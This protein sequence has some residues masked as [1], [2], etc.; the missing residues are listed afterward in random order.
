MLV[1]GPTP[2][3]YLQAEVKGTLTAR[4]TIALT[5]DVGAVVTLERAEVLRVLPQL[6]HFAEHGQDLWPDEGAE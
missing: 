2:A 6:A 5:T 3:I 1:V 4:H